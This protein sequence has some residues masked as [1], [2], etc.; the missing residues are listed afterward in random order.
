MGRAASC[1]APERE[2]C[3]G[4]SEWTLSGT[5]TQ[6]QRVRVRGCDLWAFRD[7]K[8]V[9]KDSVASRLVPP[10]PE[11]GLSTKSLGES[12]QGYP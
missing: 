10:A 4:A 3:R 9:K 6:G 1:C 2:G 7:S 11:H 5:A 12:P 8:V